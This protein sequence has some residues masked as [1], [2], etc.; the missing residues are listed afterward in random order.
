MNANAA[1]NLTRLSRRTVGSVLPREW[2]SGPTTQFHVATMCGVPGTRVLVTHATL[3]VGW[4]PAKIK[5]FISTS[6]PG[7]E[8]ACDLPA[9]CWCLALYREQDLS[10][11][12]PSGFLCF[13]PALGMQDRHIKTFELDIHM[14]WIS[15]QT[16]HVGYG[17]HLAANLGRYLSAHGPA[18]GVSIKVASSGLQVTIRMAAPNK[19]AVRFVDY[20]RA[21][22]DPGRSL[23]WNA[24]AVQV[25][26]AIEQ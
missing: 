9:G 6:E 12:S 18:T 11:R 2:V 4:A 26:Q 25:V 21:F 20:I 14:A 5:R 3:G 17:R 19:L 8:H 7:A 15:P 1:K 10:D 22:F 24:S 13:T 16:R 23:E